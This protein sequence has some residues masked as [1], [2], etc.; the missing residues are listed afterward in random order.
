MFRRSL[1]V[2]VMAVASGGCDDSKRYPT[3][4]APKTLK[5]TP[6]SATPTMAPGADDDDDVDDDD[7][8]VAPMRRPD[9]ASGPR[10]VGGGANLGGGIEPGAPLTGGGAGST[11]SINGHPKGPK[12]E[13]FNA[14]VNNAFANALACFAKATSDQT[15]SFRVQM[16]VGNQGAVEEAKVVSGP[17]LEEVRTCL[18][19]VVQR[20][21]FPPFEGP[22]V[23]QT[24]PF[25]AVR[26]GGGAA[27]P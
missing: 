9:P 16:T 5:I 1:L 20:L 24:I 21:T 11:A 12:A 19:G 18:L 13:V 15:L 14:V 3:A 10:R 27:T 4:P 22:K 17:E 26:Q 6:M 23:S 8:D 7:G 2:V 25:A